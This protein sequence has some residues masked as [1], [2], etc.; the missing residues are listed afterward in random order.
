MA[1]ATF[2]EKIETYIGPTT[3][4][5]LSTD[6]I[7]GVLTTSAR[8]LI[9]LLPEP[10]LAKA[11]A[12]SLTVNKD[13]G[14][15]IDGYR[16]LR[17]YEASR[18]AR[19]IPP[20]MSHAAV[21]ASSIYK[22]SV[23]DP[24][25][26]IDGGKLYGKPGTGTITALAVQYPSVT[27]TMD[28]GNLSAIPK[29]A[30][31]I[32]PMEAGRRILRMVESDFSTEYSALGSYLSTL[33]DFQGLEDYISD[34]NNNL[35]YNDFDTLSELSEG[36]ALLDA[37]LDTSQ[38][39][40][41]LQALVSKVRDT[42]L[43]DTM[44]VYFP[45][46]STEWSAFTQMLD[47][48]QD[49]D[50]SMAK[51]EEIKQKIV[52]WASSVETAIKSVDEREAVDLQAKIQAASSFLQLKISEIGTRIDGYIKR[53]QINASDRQTR[54]DLLLKKRQILSAE[55]QAQ[56]QATANELQAKISEIGIRIDGKIK[57]IQT[58][59]S[60]KQIEL[61]RIRLIMGS[62]DRN[63]AMALNAVGVQIGGKEQ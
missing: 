28:D 13:T 32:L 36:F 49:I 22:A 30:M 60:Y 26:Y 24:V 27:S 12:T 59:M 45:T 14:Q 20:E 37:L 16:V 34:L 1:G 7:D 54:M 40:E 33:Q 2:L 50:L 56:I 3:D 35:L 29:E 17:V 55:V 19:Q 57:E 44:L 6:Q 4:L 10:I 8:W 52:Y 62:L 61:E 46:L 5:D 38:S 41:D 9:E 48:N 53:H 18:P 23:F 25:W 39:F 42:T 63:I 21:D 31:E 15:A 58:K 51:L 11:T 47:T 43:I